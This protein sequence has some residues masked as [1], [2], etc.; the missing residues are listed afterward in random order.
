MLQFICRVLAILGGTA[1]VVWAWTFHAPAIVGLL[2]FNLG[3]IK[4]G[5]SLLPTPYG[6]MAE[7]ALRIGLMADKAMVWAEGAWAVGS[8]L[9]LVRRSFGLR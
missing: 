7:S 8:V 9:W 2:D 5:A 1:L 4:W 6:A 3:V